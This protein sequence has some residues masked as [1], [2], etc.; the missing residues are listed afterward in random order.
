M[1]VC[2]ALWVSSRPSSLMCILPAYEAKMFQC[3][4]VDHTHLSELV[5]ICRASAHTGEPWTHWKMSMTK[6]TLQ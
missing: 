6:L 2:L 1:L 3:P 4:L 5:P